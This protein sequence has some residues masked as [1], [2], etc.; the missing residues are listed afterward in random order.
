MITEQELVSE[1]MPDEL[2]KR[3]VHAMA[4]FEGSFDDLIEAVGMIVVGRVYGWKVMRLVSSR[5]RWQMASKW[6]GD[7]KLLANDVGKLADRSL[8]WRTVGHLKGFW[9]F[10]SGRASR[11]DLPL[12]ERKM[13]S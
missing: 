8:G 9:D 11:D 7:P 13:V 4:E 10:V 12:K 5:R 2:A 6:I 1:L 3:L